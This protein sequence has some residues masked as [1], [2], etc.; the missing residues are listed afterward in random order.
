MSSKARLNDE[1]ASVIGRSCWARRA[2]RQRIRPLAVCRLPASAG[3]PILQAETVRFFTTRRPLLLERVLPWDGTR[4]PSLRNR[5]SLLSARAF[6]HLR[7]HRHL[8]MDRSRKAT[9]HHAADEPHLARSAIA[10]DQKLRPAVHD[11][12][13]EALLPIKMKHNPASDTAH[14]R[15]ERTNPASADL[16]TE[17]CARD[18]GVINRED[19]KV[20]KA[21]KQVLPQ[22]CQCDQLVENALRVVA[23]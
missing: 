12:I 15:T 3:T 16:D 19:H 8:V 2:V 14:L 7:L 6:G 23:G 13:V 17:I 21:V 9:F 18:R 22:G 1:N 11:A 4:L 5:D 20:A 10:G